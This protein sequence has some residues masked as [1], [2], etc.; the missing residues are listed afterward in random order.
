[1]TTTNLNLNTYNQG[2]DPNESFEEYRM[3]LSGPTNSNMT[4]FACWIVK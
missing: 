2:V 3:N 4:T 1:M